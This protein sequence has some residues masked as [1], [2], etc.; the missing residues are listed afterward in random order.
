MKKLLILENNQ[1][2][3]CA[4]NIDTIK[5]ILEDLGY[6]L[7]KKEARKKAKKPVSPKADDPDEDICYIGT[8]PKDWTIC[9]RRVYVPD[10]YGEDLGVLKMARIIKEYGPDSILCHLGLL[11]RGDVFWDYPSVRG[12]MKFADKGIEMAVYTGTDNLQ[13]RITAAANGKIAFFFNGGTKEKQRDI[14]Q[15]VLDY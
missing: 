4:I 8:G 9:L 5:D 6:R 3:I 14:I 13:E 12:L 15:K 1:P 7:T 10:E 11:I 2:D